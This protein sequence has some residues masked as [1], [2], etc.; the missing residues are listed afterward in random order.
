VIAQSETIAALASA[1]SKAQAS[2]EGAVKGKVNP[3][4]RTKYADLASVWD[5]CREALTENGLSVIQSPG[6]VAE[7]RMEMTTMLLHASGEWVR[8]SLTIPLGKVDAQAYGSATTYAR[9]YA[10]AAFV[11]V[12]PDDD[13]GNAATKAKPAANAPGVITGRELQQQQA[14]SEGRKSSAQ[15]KRDEDDVKI[16][17]DIAKANKDGLRDWHENFDSYTAHL[18]LSWLDSVRDMLELR[19]EELNAEASVAGEAAQMDEAFRASVGPRSAGGV[20]RGNGHDQ[21]AA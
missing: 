3:A 1:L 15:A 6:P 20:A 5:A 9:R 2:V 19:L 18:P 10:L 17:D 11:G 14:T 12:A 16:K 4:F 21:A 13:D 7:G 8:G